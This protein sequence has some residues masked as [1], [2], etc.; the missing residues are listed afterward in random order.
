MPGSQL[1]RV[2]ESQALEQMTLSGGFLAVLA[3]LELDTDADADIGDAIN[4]IPGLEIPG[5]SQS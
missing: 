4:H 1:G 5:A 2:L 3:V